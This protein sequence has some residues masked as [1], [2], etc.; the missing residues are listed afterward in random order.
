MVLLLLLQSPFHPCERGRKGQIITLVNLLGTVMMLT[1]P[2]LG[3]QLFGGNLIEKSALLGGT[4][5]SVGQVVAGA[6]LLDN[7]VVEFAMLFKIL[8]IMMLVVV[9]YLFE[10]SCTR[11][12]QLCLKRQLIRRKTKITASLVCIRVCDLL[13]GQQLVFFTCSY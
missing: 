7:S 2:F 11:N 4:L 9:V 8:R 1:L 13:F 3:L 5:Q 6:S 10:N 12:N